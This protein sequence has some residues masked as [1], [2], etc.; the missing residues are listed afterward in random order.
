MPRS[1][2]RIRSLSVR[3][4]STA[5]QAPAAAEAPVAAEVPAVV[6]VAA[7][8]Q[9]A[10]IPSSTIIESCFYFKEIPGN[11]LLLSGILF[12]LY[13]FLSLFFFHSFYIGSLSPFG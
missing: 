8:T 7:V 11:N 6:E 4:G 10:V 12:Y 3:K 5:R 1:P 13:S 2:I 9:V